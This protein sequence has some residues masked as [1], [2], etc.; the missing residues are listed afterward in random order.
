MR[1]IDKKFVD[2]VD[3]LSLN[4][5]PL[6]LTA[7]STETE[8]LHQKIVGIEEGKIIR[9]TKDGN[10]YYLG[11]LGKYLTVHVQCSMGSIGRSSS[12]LTVSKAIEH[13]NPKFIIM[14]GIAFGV[15]ERKQKIGDVFIS[16]SIMPYDSKRVGKDNVIS[17]GSE[18]LSD[19]LLLNR[20]ENILSWEFKLECRSNA[21]QIFTQ[22]LSGES[23]VDNKNFRNLLIKNFPLAEGGEMEGIGLAS[24]CDGKVGWILVKGICDFA[25]GKKSED[26]NKKQN[27]AINA[28]LDLC[29]QLFENEITFEEFQVNPYKHVDKIDRKII[30]FNEYTLESEKYYIER[31][32]DKI[33]LSNF[34]DFCLWVHG[35]S[36]TGKT[37]LISRNLI[38]EKKEFILIG[39]GSYI[40][41]SMIEIFQGILIELSLIL[42][43]RVELD[44]KTVSAIFKEIIKLLSKI[45]DRKVVLMI[46]EIPLSNEKDYKE[47][48][49]YFI[50]FLIEKQTKSNL[51]NSTF[52][53][54]KS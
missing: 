53:H 9:F 43:I 20:F 36:G 12:I 25:D 50:S 10:T 14:V 19:R 27:I 46:E 3:V 54:S 44:E 16:K 1:Y 47:F 35:A 26:K 21:R 2:I 15:D 49:E 8:A 45:S 41:T 38:K 18:C 32:D 28:A 48:I 29:M 31:E 24:A 17:R 6:V 52:A 5:I 30:L 13:I 34:I 39:L 11:L 4:G 23:L 51:N 37:T 22:V 7:T 40:N 33:F 42:Q